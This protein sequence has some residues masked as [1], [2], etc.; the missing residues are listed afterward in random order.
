M[1]LAISAINHNQFKSVYYTVRTYN[2]DKRTLRQWQAR[3]PSRQEYIF[4]SK[5]LIELEESVIIQ[6]SLDLDS[7]GFSSKL[8]IIRDIVNKL[9]AVY[10]QDNVDI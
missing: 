3:I 4:K 2:V 9:L 10:S 8:S 7:R 1:S 5:K 6:Y